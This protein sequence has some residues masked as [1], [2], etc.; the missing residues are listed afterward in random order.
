MLR[1]WVGPLKQNEAKGAPGLTA[2]LLLVPV[3]LI[4]GCQARAAQPAYT[5]AARIR[6][7]YRPQIAV[8]VNG[9]GPFWCTLDSGAGSGFLLDRAIGEAA[10]LHGTRRERGFG[11]GP[12][13][14]VDEIVPDTALKVGKLHLPRQ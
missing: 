14:V 8:R 6:A 13:S 10:G 2:V 3:L 9:A 5:L 1:S 4:G 7:G 11:A 12:D